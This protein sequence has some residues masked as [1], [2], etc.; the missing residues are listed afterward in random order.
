MFFFLPLVASLANLNKNIKMAMPVR[1]ASACVL[2]TV[3]KSSKNICSQS[4]SIFL[5][6]RRCISMAAQAC[7][8]KNRYI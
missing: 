5:Q 3:I 7:K 8:Y 6:Q 4:K 2:Q 1:L